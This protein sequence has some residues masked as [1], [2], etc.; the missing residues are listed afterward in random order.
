MHAGRDW[1]LDVDYGSASLEVGASYLGMLGIDALLGVVAALE[2]LT[3]AAI[4]E[5]ASSPAE[6]R[7]LPPSASAADPAS[8]AGTAQAQAHATTEEPQSQG[9]GGAPAAAPAADGAAKG[10]QHA[11]RE[12]VERGTC[13]AMVGAVWRPLL[14][15]LSTLLART[16]G[17]A[18][19]V[20]LLKV[21]FCYRPHAD[22]HDLC[23]PTP[24]ACRNWAI[25][26]LLLSGDEYAGHIA[27]VLL[28]HTGLTFHISS[29][30]V[31]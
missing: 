22:S 21:F 27:Q 20:Q 31:C 14:A 10:G 19:I 18:L 17:E 30:H 9:N 29:T 7:Q 26:L 16:S 1:S 28:Q 11:G 2:K 6:Q 12:A 23:P 3:D 5:E 15:A 13:E 24:S 8:P 4:D 25:C